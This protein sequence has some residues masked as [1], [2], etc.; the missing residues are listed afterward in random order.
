MARP[1]ESLSLI[2]GAL[3]IQTADKD[4]A[5][6]PDGVYNLECSGVIQAGTGVSDAHSDI[7][8]PEV[9]HAVWQAALTAP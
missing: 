2:Q 4:Y 5:F 9:A 1:V 3:T 6:A 8:H 7:C